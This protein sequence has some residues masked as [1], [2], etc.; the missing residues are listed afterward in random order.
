MDNFIYN[1]LDKYFKALSNLGY[2]NYNEVEN[3][4]ILLA[5]NDLKNLCD[6]NL[7]EEELKSVD[8]ALYCLYGKSC[9]I[10][11]P[12]SDIFTSVFN[13]NKINNN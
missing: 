8:N 10:P 2:I 13:C 7:T 11:Y 12:E 9:F 1:S 6:Y 4:L 5:L 3:L